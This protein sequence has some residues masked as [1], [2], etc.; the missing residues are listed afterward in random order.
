MSTEFNDHLSDMGSAFTLSGN[1]GR[2]VFMTDFSLNCITLYCVSVPSL[3][4]SGY[5][6]NH[7]MKSKTGQGVTA[8]SSSEVLEMAEGGKIHHFYSLL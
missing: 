5:L 6:L 7:F 8:L 3:C 4:N 2:M 1:K